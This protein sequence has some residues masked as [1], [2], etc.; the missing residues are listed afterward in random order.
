MAL[1]STAFAQSSAD[2]DTR[3][4]LDQ[5]MEGQKRESES[6]LLEDADALDVPTS[7]E[8]DGQTYSVG[9]NA[10]DMGK[11]LYISITRKQWPDVQRFLAAYR[12]YPDRDPMLVHYGKGGLAREGGDLSAA[13][14][15]YRALLAL[16]ADFLPGQLELARVL[17]ENHK[18]REAR[19]AFQAAHTL[20]AEEGDQAV[21]VRQTVDAFL[22]A[23][24][25]RRGWQGRI[26]VGPTYSTNLNQ[27]SASYTCLLEADDG[28][29]LF[30]RKVPDPI[31]AAGVNFEAT[32][33]RDIPLGGHHG[34]RARG[35]LYGDIYPDQHDYSQA[36]AIGR[37]GYRYQSA[38]NTIALSP[39]FEIGSLGSS[40]LYDAPGINAE[41]THI[42]SPS[43][44]LRF[45]GAYRD[46]RYRLATYDRQDGPLTDIS[47]TA[48]YAVAPG[49]TLFGGPD[50]SV[51]D[52]D[53]PVDSY[54]QGGVRLGLNKSFGTDASLLLIGSYRYRRYRA[55]SELFAA[56]RQDDQF[57][58]TAIA[59][60]PA[61][62]F[63]GL[64]P[65]IVVQHTH[66]E[67]N[68]DWLY[69]YDRT[70]ASLRLSHAF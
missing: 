41:W 30:D 32:L 10:N 6:E 64:V 44:T 19:R 31:A 28:T 22:H 62:K 52:T 1:P 14:A 61:L 7:L 66:I 47:L 45:E 27:S 51:K 57:N 60:F 38:R 29:C 39:S 67:S 5:Q 43:A 3:L 4:R 35:L 69:S 48:W 2:Q 24:E 18:D 17:F 59:R 56:Q 49:W 23:L 58:A 68:I 36:T 12:R 33:G 37:V 53:D 42:L 15:E 70:S 46:F 16:Q 54:D 63:A 21:N 9:D 8:I 25:R 20:L 13:E 55:Y 11:A 26:A 50:F 34:I 40:I 65:E